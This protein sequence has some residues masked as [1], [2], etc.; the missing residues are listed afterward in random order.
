LRSNVGIEKNT[1]AQTVKQSNAGGGT[2]SIGACTQLLYWLHALDCLSRST[3]TRPGNQGG[4]HRSFGRRGAPWHPG[5]ACTPGQ[6]TRERGGAGYL[7]ELLRRRRRC[8]VGDDALWVRGKRFATQP[9]L[10]YSRR[11]LPGRTGPCQNVSLAFD[12]RRVER[13]PA[14]GGVSMRVRSRCPAEYNPIQRYLSANDRAH[15]PPTRADANRAAIG[16][17]ESS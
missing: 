14:V 8:A 9:T 11:G 5:D 17:D 15:S 4:E 16:G 12:L 6:A 7:C 10:M 3:L 2:R 1:S 13:R